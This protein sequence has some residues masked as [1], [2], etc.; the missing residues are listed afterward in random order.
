[1]LWELDELRRV[2]GRH[3]LDA[4]SAVFSVSRALLIFGMCIRDGRMSWSAIP[5]SVWSGF[6]VPC[7]VSLGVAEIGG[8][9]DLSFAF[10]DLLCEFS[11]L[12]CECVWR[13]RLSRLCTRCCG[14]LGSWWHLVC[15]RVAVPCSPGFL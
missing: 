9:G 11:R 14:C 6:H 5:P 2:S 8:C 15:C 3:G 4:K 12:L 10:L 13:G 7:A 1:M